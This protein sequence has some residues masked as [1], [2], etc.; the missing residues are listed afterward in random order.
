MKFRKMMTVLLSS[1]SILAFAQMASASQS[2]PGVSEINGGSTGAFERKQLGFS[3]FDGIISNVK[4]PYIS[5]IEDGEQ[6]WVYYGFET[7]PETTAPVKGIEVGFSHQSGSKKWLPYVKS[8]AAGGFIYG[9]QAFYDGNLYSNVKAYVAKNASDGKY[10]VRLIYGSTELINPGKGVVTAF[11]DADFQKLAVK[12]VTGI[13]EKYGFDG[14]SNIKAK[15][16]SQKWENVQVSKYDSGNYYSWSNYSEYK[17]WNGK[18]WF[19]TID[20]VPAYIH[21]DTVGYTSIYK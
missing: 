1:A 20:C 8:A 16:D 5:G 14:V 11:T 7:T 12:R 10:Y 18:Q 6:A 13:G 4:L 17:W 15:S 21:H 9:T 2:N 19:G 3:G